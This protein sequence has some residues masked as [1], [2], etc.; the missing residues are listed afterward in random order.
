MLLSPKLTILSYCI[1]L[2]SILACSSAQAPQDDATPAAEAETNTSLDY[3]REQLRPQLHL[4]PE[5]GW[6]GAPSGLVFN[7]NNYHLYYLQNTAT[8]K[9]DK[10]HWGHATSQNLVEW[11]HQPFALAP[12]QTSDILSGSVIL[13]KNNT[14]GFGESA[15]IA[16]YTQREAA[17]PSL[18]LA[19]STDGGYTWTKAAAIPTLPASEDIELVD[20]DLFW[21]STSS[22]WI[23]TLAAGNEIRFYAS[24]DLKLWEFKSSY[25][26][27]LKLGEATGAMYERPSM[28][29]LRDYL[30]STLNY[31]L[32]L[33]V[34]DGA[35]AG[36][37]GT[38]Y[39]IGDFDGTRFSAEKNGG[40]Y[41]LD[42]G[43]DSYAFGTFDN[44]PTPENRAL[45]IAWM[46]NLDY[47]TKVPTEQW[48]GTMTSPRVLTL[49]E[50]PLGP[51][52]KQQLVPDLYNF[53]G[54]R[55]S[56]NR[57]SDKIPTDLQSSTAN[58]SNSTLDIN[59]NTPE[60]KVPAF[61]LVLADADRDTV[62]VGYDA[63][64]EEYFI[65]R[66]G[67]HSASFSEKYSS[68]HTAPRKSFASGEILRILIDRSSIEVF[69]DDGFTVLTDSYFFDDERTNLYLEGD[70]GIEGTI[71]ELKDSPP[72]P[73]SVA[74]VRLGLD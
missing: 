30:T 52:L 23:L 24:P 25:G 48:R 53:R 14:A 46:S 68:R 32:F 72:T 61:T 41:W 45:G 69:A 10:L 56:F 31:V 74:R 5:K 71:Y 65:D 16:L 4:T 8:N 49:H 1:L 66:T 50:T 19:Y 26:R 3:Y 11:Q 57:M 40:A 2:C 22:Q 55:L 70:V 39:I 59:L 33:N 6:M 38:S 28:I 21:H 37:S 44:S 62:R 18:S 42:Y 64:Q 9:P 7:D 73:E 20:P 58:W 27:N 51:R 54:A 29:P 47:A 60:G 34:P 35:P 63:Q 67:L 36:G 15:L 12:D 13:D 43:A 17:R